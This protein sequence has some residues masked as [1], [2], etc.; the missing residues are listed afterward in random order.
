MDTVEHLGDKDFARLKLGIGRPLHHEPVESYVLHSPYPE[1]EGAFEEMIIR[2]ADAA[3]AVLLSGM[4]RAMNL[5][6]TSDTNH[7]AP[8]HAS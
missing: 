2:G 7:E 3:R 5:F 1:Q 8:L 6:N 4:V